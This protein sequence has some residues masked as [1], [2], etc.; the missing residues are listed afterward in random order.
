MIDQIFS[1]GSYQAVKHML[2]LTS[3]RHEALAGN[4][5]NVETPG[6]H[7]VDLDRAAVANFQSSMRTAADT[8]SF[9]AASAPNQ[10]AV[11]TTLD[12]LAHATRADGNNVEIDQELL[13]MSKNTVEYSTLSEFASS[14]LKCLR[15]AIS[16]QVS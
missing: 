8:G 4:I 3:Q 6:Y 5:A 11:R 12:T 7:R 13:T 2:D 16:G 10:P 9:E 14:S 15:M 1:G